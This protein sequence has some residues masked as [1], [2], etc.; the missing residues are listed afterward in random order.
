M[1]YAR[2]NLQGQR[3]P[4][5]RKIDP[6]ANSCQRLG[7]FLKLLRILTAFAPARGAIPPLNQAPK[8]YKPSIIRDVFFIVT[9]ALYLQCL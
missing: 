4:Y 5:F 3:S 2:R 8:G 1:T 6:I 7:R 9:G